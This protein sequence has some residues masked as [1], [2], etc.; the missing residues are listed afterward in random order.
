MSDYAATHA[1]ARRLVGRKGAP[2]VFTSTSGGTYDPLTPTTETGAMARTV[3]GSA[4]RV[5][6]D[7]L[8]YQ[9]LELIP[10]EA[11]TLEFVPDVYGAMPPLGASVV[12]GGLQYIVRDVE[13]IAPDGTAIAARIVVV[14]GGPVPG[15]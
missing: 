3:S 1:R 13:P 6:G 11:P 5:A 14:G 2:V 15:A 4:A 10:S 9:A 8:R 12:F 7:P